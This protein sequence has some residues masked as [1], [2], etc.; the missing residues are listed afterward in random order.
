MDFMESSRSTAQFTFRAVGPA[1]AGVALALALT[2]ALAPV[3]S[4]QAEADQA[5]L[6]QAGPEQAIPEQAGPVG[7]VPEVAAAVEVLSP[8]AA[9]PAAIP[10]PAVK[11][12]MVDN[13]NLPG[14][15]TVPVGTTV[16]WVNAGLLPHT[17]SAQRGALESGMVQ[18]GQSY[19]FTF[20]SPG[21]YT[22]F[23]RPH[24]VIGMT[25]VVVVE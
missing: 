25:G 11:V 4:A 12:T 19:S 21:E 20:D 1:V 18:P 10:V 3:V 17:V 5:G 2:L 23:C 13:R 9:A 7:E 24:V 14:R 16:T 6:A 8:Q 15:V 22:Y